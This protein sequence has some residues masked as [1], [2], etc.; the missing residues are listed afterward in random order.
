MKNS[1]NYHWQSVLFTSWFPVFWYKWWSLT[2]F[3][4][5]SREYN[6][7]IFFFPDKLL[8]NV[9]IPCLEIKNF[10]IVLS[11]KVANGCGQSDRYCRINRPQSLI[12]SQVGHYILVLGEGF[13]PL[14]MSLALG[15]QIRYLLPHRLLS[16]RI[17]RRILAAQPVLWK[18]QAECCVGLFLLLRSYA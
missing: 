2:V 11:I 14:P 7:I 9:S 6:I 10:Q 3:N 16:S 13:P 15:G 12:S 4:C 1:S 17:W 8:V 5:L 18:K